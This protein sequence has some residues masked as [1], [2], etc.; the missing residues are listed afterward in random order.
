M[1]LNRLLEITNLLLNR[2]SVTAAELA[3]RFGVSVRTVYRDIDALSVSGIPVVTSQGSGGGISLMEGFTV[4]RTAMTGSERDGLMFALQALQATKYPQLDA[5]IDRIMEKPVRA[6]WVAVDFTPWGSNPNAH[7][8]FTVIKT[9]ILQ[10]RAIHIQYIN[11]DNVK[12]EREIEPFKLI[13][14]GQAWYMWGYC[15]KRMDYRLFRVSRIKKAALL[16]RVFDRDAVRVIS[17][18]SD[19]KPDVRLL[20]VFTE[21]ALSRLYDDCDEHM[22]TQNDDGTYTLTVD[23]PEDE[24]IYGYILSFGPSVRVASPEHIRRGVEERL[25][26][27]LGQYQ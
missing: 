27:T 6:D 24:W 14:K 10:S 20:L 9:A 13:F 2:K 26:R 15:L 7:E 25:R 8:R 23:L 11:A 19:E 3:E 16:D 18:P 5:L 1:K 21:D 12:S 17:P 4:N 22:V